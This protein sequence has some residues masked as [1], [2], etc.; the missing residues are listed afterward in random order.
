MNTEVLC[1]KERAYYLT[2]NEIAETRVK[3]F[4]GHKKNADSFCNLSA[5]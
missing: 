4:N 3:L 2:Q 5:F 1:G